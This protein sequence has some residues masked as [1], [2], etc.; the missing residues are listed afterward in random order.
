MI[1][2][3]IKSKKGSFYF[4]HRGAQW[5][6]PENTLIAFKKAITL[7][8]DGVE[9]DIQIT[10]D[11][12]III[13]HDR[14]ILSK[15]KKHFI[16]KLNYQEIK[17]ICAQKKQP[18]PELFDFILPIMKKNPHIIFN[19]EIKSDCYNNNQIIKLLDRLI[20][21]SIKNNQCIF[22]SFNYC[23]LFQLKLYFKNKTFIGLIFGSQRMKKKP[24]GIFNKFIIKLIKPHCLHL[25]AN[26]MTSELV[27]WAT[28]N[29]IIINS[30]TINE[31]QQLDTVRA[32]GVHGIFTDNHELYSK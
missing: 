8:C 26:Y 19:I 2:K 10:K 30:Y 1:I 22:S 28:F 27:G 12:K 16:S 15:N 17:L 29:K 24:I 31:K 5:L 14:H 25:N 3:K 23:L 6:Y 13:F 11:N 9:M 20:P 18:T 7:G 32:M 21:D 4:A